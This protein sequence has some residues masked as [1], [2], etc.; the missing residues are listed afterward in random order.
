MKGVVDGLITYATALCFD[1]M[2]SVARKL[3][4]NVTVD[5]ALRLL[6]FDTLREGSTSPAECF[7]F[8]SE[9]LARPDALAVCLNSENQHSTNS[10]K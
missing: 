10:T 1:L 6:D 8:A 3:L 7:Q 2:T 4:I 5:V 9:P